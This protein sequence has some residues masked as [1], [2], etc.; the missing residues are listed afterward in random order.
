MNRNLVTGLVGVCTSTLF[1]FG[2]SL[3]IR[4]AYTSLEQHNLSSGVIQQAGGI[5]IATAAYVA[6]FYLGRYSKL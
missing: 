3:V 2:I 4:S 5:C 1:F 6:V